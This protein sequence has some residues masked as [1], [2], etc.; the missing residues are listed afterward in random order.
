MRRISSMGPRIIPSSGFKHLVLIYSLDSGKFLQVIQK[1]CT[2]SMLLNRLPVFILG[3]GISLSGPIQ[4]W[5]LT[6][7]ICG[8]CSDFVLKD[9]CFVSVCTTKC[10]HFEN[11]M[12]LIICIISLQGYFSFTNVLL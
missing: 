7:Y 3:F 11:F 12:F 4:L 6:F 2:D 8:L 5:V 9:Q 10:F 1:H